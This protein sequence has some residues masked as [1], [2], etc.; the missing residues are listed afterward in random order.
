VFSPLSKVEEEVGNRLAVEAL[1]GVLNER[2]RQVISARF[3]DHATLSEAGQEIG[4]VSGARARQIESLAIR[5]M[6]RAARVPSPPAPP[7]TARTE[8]TN[9]GMSAKQADAQKVAQY[10]C[11]KPSRLFR[12]SRPQ[13]TFWE[14]VKA[15]EEM[16][17]AAVAHVGPGEAAARLA[18]YWA[19]HGI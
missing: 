7:Q 10:F 13:Q 5:K 16:L 15:T 6:R 19:R 11:N 2:E 9:W 4:P 1:L 8:Q 17:A 18:A 12:P 3:F 14:G